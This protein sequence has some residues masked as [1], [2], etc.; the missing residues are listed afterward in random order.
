MPVW[1]YNVCVTVFECHAVVP[2]PQES[3]TGS[4]ATFVTDTNFGS[5]EDGSELPERE[6]LNELLLREAQ[7][8]IRGCGTWVRCPAPPCC[9][10]GGSPPIGQT[11]PPVVGAVPGG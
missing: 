6:D 5:E 10:C 3:A 8:G 9:Q 7:V 4:V 1:R 2:P 11:P